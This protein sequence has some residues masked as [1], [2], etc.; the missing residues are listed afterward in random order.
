M[1]LEFTR[2]SCTQSG[3]V[4]EPAFDPTITIMSSIVS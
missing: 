2:R 1:A 3:L 4:S